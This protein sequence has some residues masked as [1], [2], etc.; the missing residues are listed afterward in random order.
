MSDMQVSV[1]NVFGREF[2]VLA[3]PWCD[4]RPCL[5]Q[6]SD[7]LYWILTHT[8]RLSLMATIERLIYP[9]VLKVFNDLFQKKKFTDNSTPFR[10]T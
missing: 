2:F 5:I 10:R 7:G 8:N 1:E 6:N 4:V 3:G 9:G